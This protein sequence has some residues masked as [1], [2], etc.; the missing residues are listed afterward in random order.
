MPTNEAA[1]LPAKHTRL[2]VGLAPYPAPGTHEIVVRNRAVA[3]NPVDWI[4]QA[5]GTMAF[6]W[7]K[8]PAVLGSDVAGEVAAVGAGV[9]RFRVG[10]RVVGHA[11][12]LNKT[13]SGAPEGA[14]QLY[15]VLL[16]HMASPLPDGVSFDEAAVL[17]LGLSTAACG[18]FE[19]D[20]L[21]LAL[22][23]AGAAATG[24]TVLVWGGSTSVGSNAIQ[25][26]VAAGY[27]VVTTASPRNFD[28]VKGLGASL[29]FDYASPGV[30]ADLIGAMAGRTMA[31]ALAIGVGSAP[32]C[33]QVVRACRGRKFVSM[34]SP[35][36]SFAKVPLGRGRMLAMAPLMARFAGSALALAVNGRRW[37]VGTKFIFGS[38]LA[39]N[40]VG[41]AIYVDYLPRALAEGR[42]VAAPPAMVVGQGLGD[43]QAALDAQRAGVSASKLV[44]RV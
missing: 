37:G 7:V 44:V 5:V 9:T 39:D 18:L 20:Q 1:W 36:V 16:A 6:P 3:I 10:D 8:Y 33:M 21:A 24:K 14:F 29:A 35:A 13:R 28:Y 32:K 42:F 11:I 38:S 27:E 43:L 2:E 25:L 34:A 41:P 17:P 30:V 26:A 40:E 31:G 12:G 19:K 15:T 4:I 22:P 23:S